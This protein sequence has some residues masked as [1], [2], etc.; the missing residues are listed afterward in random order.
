M[1][2]NRLS[3]A[4]GLN[5][6]LLNV[7]PVP[8]VSVRNPTTRDRA[9]LG[10]LW[11]NK[12][13]N[14]YFVLTSVVANVSTWS[15]VSNGAGVFTS[16]EATT[17]DITADLGNIVATVGSVTAG[18]SMAAGASVIAGTFITAGTDITATAGDITASAGNITAVL[19]SVNAGNGL[20]VTTGDAIVSSGDIV[21]NAGNLSIVLGNATVGAGDITAVTG[22]IEASAGAVRGGQLEATDD[23]GGVAAMTSFT[24]AVNTTQGA[25]TL[26]ILSASANPGNNA[27]FLK[28]YVGTTTAYV[29][30][31]TDVAP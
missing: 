27:G 16:L 7:F 14:D 10:T 3:P 11:V 4:Y 25:G 2:S 18:N 6:P 23:L 24:N 31:F 13:T 9:Q 28:I 8:I 5:D 12:D 20:T 21:A 26:S 22:D 19:G 1:A 17:G 30:Y 15:S 29:P